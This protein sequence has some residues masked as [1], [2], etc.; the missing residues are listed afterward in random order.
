MDPGGE[1]K[2]K[3]YFIQCHKL[4]VTVHTAVGQI[5][6]GQRSFLHRYSYIFGFQLCVCRPVVKL[7]PERAKI[8]K[9]L[10]LKA[11]S[12]LCNYAEVYVSIPVVNVNL[13]GFFFSFP[14]PK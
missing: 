5:R 14:E 12:F 7:Y 2:V 9:N 3:Y 6:S 13:P 1:Q 11:S 8:N 10:L 4:I